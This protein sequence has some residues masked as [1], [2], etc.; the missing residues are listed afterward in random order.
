M[1]GGCEG[2]RLRCSCWCH[3]EWHSNWRN[4]L[5]QPTQRNKTCL[6]REKRLIGVGHNRAG[7]TV[8]RQ[9]CTGATWWDLLPAATIYGVAEVGVPLICDPGDVSPEDPSGRE[10]DAAGAGTS[11]I[12]LTLVCR[13]W[14]PNNLFLKIFYP[15]S[16]PRFKKKKKGKKSFSLPFNSFTCWVISFILF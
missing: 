7:S 11:D 8:A 5:H 15:L 6:I 1:L 13:V 9:P 3:W 14:I 12:L 16:S 10:A 2:W 4:S